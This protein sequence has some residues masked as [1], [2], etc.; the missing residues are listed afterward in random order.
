VDGISLGS[1]NAAAMQRVYRDLA[2]VRGAPPPVEQGPL[3][4][5]PHSGASSWRPSCPSAARPPTCTR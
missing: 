4:V 3:G 2:A 5:V 1:L